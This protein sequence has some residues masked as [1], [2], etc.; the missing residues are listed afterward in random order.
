MPVNFKEKRREGK[1]R[2]FRPFLTSDGSDVDPVLCPD[3]EA[4]RTVRFLLEL[5][6]ELHDGRVTGLVTISDNDLR[7]GLHAKKSA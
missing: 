3:A 2:D 4:E 6:R 5:D 1:P 7:A